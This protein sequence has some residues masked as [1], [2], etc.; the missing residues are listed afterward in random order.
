MKI[1]I[2]HSGDMKT[3]SLGGVDQYIKSLI[4]FSNNSEITVFGTT[5]IGEHTLGRAYNQEYC[6]KKYTF[7]P[8]SDN[9]RKPLSAYYLF[10]E[11]FWVR[12][13]GQYDCIYAQRTEYS[14]PFLFSKNKHKLIQM[15]HGSSKYSEI[16]FGKSLAKIHLLMEKKAISVAAYTFI[17]LN[18]KEYGVPYYQERYIKYANRIKYGKNLIDTGLYYKSDKLSS[19]KE[20]NICE[21]EIIIL[22]SGRLEHNPKRILLLPCICKELLSRNYNIKF[23]ILGDG[24]DRNN[25]ENLIEQLSVVDNFVIKGYIDDPHIIAKYNHVSD[26]AINLSMFE[27]TCTSVLESLAC[28]VPI[29]STDVG[30]IHECLF[31]NENGII[32]PNSSDSEIVENAVAAIEAIINKKPVMNDIFMKYSG[33]C[34]IKELK[35]FIEQNIMG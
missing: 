23:Y 19:R 21:D 8:I 5:M 29:V 1:A 13:L 11:I 15:I 7:I 16:G 34:V 4:A 32:I 12:K 30:D 18:R 20:F 31:N 33:D 28:G 35:R 25:L 9:K 3:V 14:L 22:F 2:L 17:I 27:G 10:R 6:G 26:I 24:S